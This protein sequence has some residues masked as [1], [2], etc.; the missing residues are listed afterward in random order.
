MTLGEAHHQMLKGKVVAR[1]AWPE[2]AKNFG[3]AVNVVRGFKYV[4][5][6]KG[7]TWGTLYKPMSVDWFAKDWE[8][9]DAYPPV[10][11]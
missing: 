1:R 9:V 2:F 7:D 10:K 5:M 11:E 6:C 3:I 4:Q 8:V